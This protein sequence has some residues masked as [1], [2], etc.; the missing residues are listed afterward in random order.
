MF[1]IIGRLSG[2]YLYKMLRILPEWIATVFKIGNLPIAPGTWGSLVGVGIWATIFQKFSL[3]VQLLLIILIFFLGVWTSTVI[4]KNEEESD[5]SRIV[6]DEMVGQWIALLGLPL[7]L[8]IV[9]AGFVLFRIFDILKP[10]PVR[11]CEKW[12]RGWGV[13]GDDIAAGMLTFC[14]LTLY[15]IWG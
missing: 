11:Q 6:I 2:N 3:N 12:P 15:R 8:P 1:M 14:C 5:P 13:M 7:S 9:F 10:P 4:V